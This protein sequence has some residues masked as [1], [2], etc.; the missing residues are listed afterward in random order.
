[1]P[2][3]RVSVVTPV[4]NT[5][6]YLAECIESVLSQTFGDFEYVILDNASTDDSADII[7][8]YARGDR[9]IRVERNEQLLPQIHNYNRAL[10]L[11]GAQSRYTKIVQ[12]DDWIFP[13]CLARMVEVAESHENIVIV[14]ALAAKGPA[15]AGQGLPY[16]SRHV[17]GRLPCRIHL[18]QGLSLFG[19]PTT[20]LYRSDVVRARTRFFD[21]DSLVDDVEICY[22][23]LRDHDFGFVHELL[24]Y[25][26]VDDDSITG[27]IA[28]YNPYLLHGLILLTK[29]GS[30]FL[31]PE[32]HRTA[33]R[34]RR[35][36]YF[37][38]LGGAV[39]RGREA[40]F[41]AHHQQGLAA[42]GETLTLGRRVR[43]AA[44]AALDLALNPLNTVRTLRG[45]G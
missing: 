29:Y 40:G 34:R 28:A 17:P 9:R 6:K 3:P 12:A 21:P 5:G 25:I 22:Q 36:D 11:I 42:I 41:W 38:F 39:L 18:L 20:L 24:S 35:R 33:L 4:Y 2:A 10:S 19:T 32:E 14:G 16:P 43:L 27:G 23:L 13:Q 30:D 7:A 44:D 1:M 8:R 45:D 26:R 37:R 31:T 15:I